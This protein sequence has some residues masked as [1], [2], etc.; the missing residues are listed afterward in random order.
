[1]KLCPKAVAIRSGHDIKSEYDRN[2]P[3]ASHD[4]VAMARALHKHMAH[5][6]LCSK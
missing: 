3:I 1:M 6:K 5:C 2:N 4:K